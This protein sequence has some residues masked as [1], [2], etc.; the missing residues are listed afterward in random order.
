M[1]KLAFGAG[2]GDAAQ[3]ELQDEGDCV[4]EVKERCYS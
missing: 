3:V 4:H 1:A 2:N